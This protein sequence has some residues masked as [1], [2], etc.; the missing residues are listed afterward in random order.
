MKNIIF[1]L[2]IVSLSISNAQTGSVNYTVVR[3]FNSTAERETVLYFNNVESTYYDTPSYGDIKGTENSNESIE[4]IASTNRTEVKSVTLLNKEPSIYHNN[5]KTNSLFCRETS[6]VNNFKF[7]HF[8]FKDYGAINLP[9]TLNDEFKIISGY[10]CQKATVNFRGRTYEAWFTTE[11]PLPYGPWK[12]GG[13]PGLILEAYDLSK[14]VLF[15]ATKVTIPDPN[16]PNMI[17]KPTGKKVTLKEFVTIRN[18]RD[19]SIEKAILS[20]MPK[21]SKILGSKTVSPKSNLELEYKWNEE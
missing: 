3:S 14:A 19:S 16:A 8:L 4:E 17:L 10:N 6:L 21:G 12:L 9:W 1:T 7:E 20:R 13:L 11:I 2:F 15:N 18:N 5:L